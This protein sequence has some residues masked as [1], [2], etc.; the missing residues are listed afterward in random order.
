[1]PQ[2]DP[3]IALNPQQQ[4]II[5]MLEDFARK[6]REQILNP[7]G[8][9]AKQQTWYA[10]QAALKLQGTER[11]LARLGVKLAELVP[12]SMQSHFD[13]G[14]ADANK[15]LR[16][17][18]VLDAGEPMQGS[19]ALV[20]SERAQVVIRET[21]DDLAKAA[22]TT[23]DTTRKAVREI[24]ALGLDK[25]KVR[26]L[27]A[28]GTI[29]GQPKATLSALRKICQGAADKEGKLWVM[30]K[31][32]E[33]MAFDPHSYADMVFQTR[34]AESANIAT[35]ERLDDKG[36]HY[37]KIIGSNSSNFCT[38]F[39]GKVYWSGTGEDP[40]GLYPSLRLLPD[41]GPPFHPRCTKR[42]VAFIMDLQSAKAIQKA[43]P[44]DRTRELH[45]KSPA[46]A[47]KSYAA[48]KP[49]PKKPLTPAQL[50]R[51][52][53]DDALPLVDPGTKVTG[54]RIPRK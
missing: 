24:N 11:E 40:Q 31:D 19:F 22:R 36:V 43:K 2:G 28:R 6:C 27:I 17:A 25:A 49:A 54:E 32:G 10:S 37:V 47:Q 12:P 44:D 15:Q 3:P 38:A 53:A 16:E 4:R 35:L 20:S 21:A 52:A 48:P 13:Q 29:E 39:V 42:F 46:Q 8:K 5:A 30:K 33:A 9:T 7:P 50:A 14:L 45:G 23:L 41:G 51:Q 26:E 18:G 1:M 34:S